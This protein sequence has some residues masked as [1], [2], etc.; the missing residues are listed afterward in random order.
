M[1]QYLRPAFLLTL[2]MEKTMQA[3]QSDQ[4]SNTLDVRAFYFSDF[5]GRP[6]LKLARKNWWVSALVGGAILGTIMIGGGWLV[7]LRYAST[8]GFLPLYDRRE[9]GWVIFVYVIVGPVIWATYAKEPYYMQRTYQDLLRHGIFP[10]PGQDTRVKELIE[11]SMSGWKSTWIFVIVV[12][13]TCLEMAQWVATQRQPDDS[14]RFGATHFWWSIDPYYYYGLW[15]IAN[16]S[17]TYMILWTLVRRFAAWFT[18]A[19]LLRAI[20]IQ[21]VLFHEDGCNGLSPIGK[22]TFTLTLPLTLGG[23]WL[24]VSILYPAFFG[25]SLNSKFDTFD[26]VIAYLVLIP[27]MFVGSTWIPH[28]EM[29]RLRNKRLQ[30]VAVKIQ[31]L[32]SQFP[33]GSDL[34]FTDLTAGNQASSH[35]PSAML[36]SIEEI[37]ALEHIHDVIER[38]QVTW[39]F[40]LPS[41]ERFFAI[42]GLPWV[43]SLAVVIFREAVNLSIHKYFP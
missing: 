35:E 21:P 7:S 4:P 13:L 41:T 15:F 2:C 29:R 12:A 28:W 6:L 26:I 9:I 8:P 32:L 40:R 19:K 37:K 31:R 16:F 17:L 30:D 18:T 39:P 14:F 36:H 23:L 33:T 42:T 1:L 11:K 34:T 3:S 25:Q 5:L 22:Y 27:T 20:Q 38:R 24:A 43:T 10:E